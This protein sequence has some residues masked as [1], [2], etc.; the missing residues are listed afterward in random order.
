MKWLIKVNLSSAECVNLSS[1]LAVQLEVVPRKEDHHKVT[2]WLYNVGHENDATH[3]DSF[4]D[5]YIEA[6]TY[7]KDFVEFIKDENADFFMIESE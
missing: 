2:T 7:I 5:S 4:H 6:C 1:G 3:M